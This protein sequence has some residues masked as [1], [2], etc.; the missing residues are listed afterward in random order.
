MFNLQY[1]GEKFNLGECDVLFEENQGQLSRFDL[2]ISAFIGKDGIRLIFDYAKD[3]FKEERIKQLAEYYETF[4]QV[5]LK[6]PSKRMLEISLLGEEERQQL[7]RWNETRQDYPRDKCIHQLFEEQA[8]KTPFNIA[9]IYEDQEI[10]YRDLNEK[11]NQLAR[12]LRKKGIGPETFV[13]IALERSIEMVVGIL[14]ILKAGGAYVPM[15]PSYPEERLIF[16]LEDTGASLLI[17]QHSLKEVFKGYNNILYIDSNWNEIQPENK[18][19]LHTDTHP[20]HLAYIIYTSG[21]TGKP[22]GV[23]VSHKEVA[24]FT[25]NNNYLQMNDKTITLSFSNYVFD[26]S[27]FDI[28]STLLNAG[29][30]ILTHKHDILNV[31]KLEQ[32]LLKHA[33]NTAFIT[34]AL[35]AY[36]SKLMDK[37]PLYH[38]SNLLFGGEKINYDDLNVFLKEKG[39]E[40]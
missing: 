13:L 9:V 14:G 37:N 7:L 15:D 29:K 4:L 28:F 34:T 33:V 23:M 1:E 17:T 24:G 30:F 35:F 21:S 20:N 6:E 5:V 25:I 10:T 16:M 26:G 40:K 18:S 2:L 3:L 22:K 19:N 8:E 38:I 11:A 27:I 31:Q 32:L 12:Y 36:Y 39:S